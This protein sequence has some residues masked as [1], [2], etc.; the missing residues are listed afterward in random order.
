MDIYEYRYI[1]LSFLLLVK[2]FVVTHCNAE[3]ICI[4][5]AN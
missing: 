2:E 5:L 3:N 1:N 4:V